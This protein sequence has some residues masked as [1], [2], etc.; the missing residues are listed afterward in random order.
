MNLNMEKQRRSSEIVRG[1]WMTPDANGELPTEQIIEVGEL[2]TI[3]LEG[4]ELALEALKILGAR[5]YDTSDPR[6]TGED[7]SCANRRCG[8]CHSVGKASIKHWADLTKTAKRQ[9]GLDKS[10]ADMTQEEAIKAVDC[11]RARPEDSSSVFAADKVGILT[12]GARYSFFRELFRKAYG[13]EPGADDETLDSSF[14]QFSSSRQHAKGVYPILSQHEYA[15]LTK[16]FDANLTN[17]DDVI[18]DPPPPSTCDEAT[19]KG[20]MEQHIEAMR[21]DGWAAVNRKMA[22][23]CLGVKPAKPRSVS[24]VAIQMSPPSG[25][26]RRPAV[27]DHEAEF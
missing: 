2:P 1:T 15:V 6:C 26:H 11:M 22:F 27:R 24:R 3:D 9:C 16:W 10:P 12:T 21:F 7:G 25:G 13:A 23:V 14:S 20:F 5:V 17:L 8:E 19:D 4:K 18:Q